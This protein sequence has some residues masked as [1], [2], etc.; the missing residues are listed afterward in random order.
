LGI[1]KVGIFSHKIGIETKIILS[2]RERRK[3]KK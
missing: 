3:I 1:V 2:Q